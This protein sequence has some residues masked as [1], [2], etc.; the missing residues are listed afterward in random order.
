LNEPADSQHK[1]LISFYNRAYKSIR[2]IDQN[3]IL[4][5]DGNTFA[6]DF[7]QFGDAYKNWS[8]T[9]YS[10]HDYSGFGFP[11]S[12]ETYVGSDEQKKKLKEVFERKRKWMVDNNLPIWNGEWG[13]VYARQQYDGEA[14]QEINKARLRVLKDQLEIYDETRLSWSIWLLKDVDGFQGMI[15]S[16]PDSAYNK[17]FKKLLAKKQFMAIDTWGTDEVHVKHIYEP[18]E[19]LIKENVS[20]QRQ[21]LYP[22]NW[23]LKRRVAELSR[24]ILV[25]E[26]LVDEWADHFVGKTMEELDELAASFSFEN[27]VQREELNAI[28]KKY[29]HL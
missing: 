21:R 4:F 27:C 26:F 11:S 22:S 7:S 29:S 18:L 12:P 28:L 6:A 2:A 16:S 23:T 17:L 1:R 10:I 19:D 15:Y 5:L 20:E 3:H 14:T 13:P 8:N 24:H 9:V 25:A